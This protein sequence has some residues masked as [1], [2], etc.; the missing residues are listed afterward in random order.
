MTVVII[1][2]T[3]HVYVNGALL[4]NCH[5]AW[6]TLRSRAV[7]DSATASTFACLALL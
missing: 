1:N 7:T 6:P 4:T 5:T 3:S 2:A